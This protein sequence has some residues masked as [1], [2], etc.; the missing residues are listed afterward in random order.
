MRKQC[1]EQRETGNKHVLE[2]CTEIRRGSAVDEIV[3]VVAAEKQ[4][5]S[6]HLS[7]NLPVRRSIPSGKILYYCACGD[8]DVWE[9]CVC[10]CVLG[11]E[12]VVIQGLSVLR[13]GMVVVIHG[14]RSVREVLCGIVQVQR[15][16][17][18]VIKIW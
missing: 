10:V 13:E 15:G 8:E 2:S 9:V 14:L 7:E 1:P 5:L 12:T 18:Y 6:S 4:V 3:E 11:E 17:V 16:K